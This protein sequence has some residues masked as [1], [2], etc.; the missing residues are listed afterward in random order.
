M[1]PI[2]QLHYFL[3]YRKFS[4]IVALAIT[5]VAQINPVR[6]TEFSEDTNTLKTLKLNNVLSESKKPLKKELSDNSNLINDSDSNGTKKSRN[7]CGL[8]CLQE[9]CV[10]HAVVSSLR[11]KLKERRLRTRG[12]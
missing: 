4:L 10:I 12:S 11:D 1:I 2:S 3:Q 9:E 5:T 6:A 8:S 7:T